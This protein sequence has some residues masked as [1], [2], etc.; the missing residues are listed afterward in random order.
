MDRYLK[1]RGKKNIHTIKYRQRNVE[2]FMLNVIY[3]DCR[4]NNCV[5]IGNI[6]A[7]SDKK[8]VPIDWNSVKFL[9]LIKLDTELLLL[10]TTKKYINIKRQ[11]VRVGVR[12]RGEINDTK[13]QNRKRKKNRIPQKKKINGNKFS[14]TSK[15]T[16]II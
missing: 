15:Q 10:Q 3:C 13:G 11:R 1:I 14:R 12:V 4:E 7:E 8:K 2:D 6:F 16:L 9:Y 5:K